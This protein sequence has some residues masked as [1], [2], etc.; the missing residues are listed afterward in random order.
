MY[1][2]LKKIIIGTANLENHYGFSK[3][4]LAIKEFKKILKLAKKKNINTLDIA[5]E[6]KNVFNIL[7]EQ[8]LTGWNIYSKISNIPNDK[9]LIDEYILSTIIQSL[10]NINFEKFKGIMIH[11]PWDLKKNN[12]HII[13]TTFKKI[14]KY[15]LSNEVGV[16]IYSNYLKK[17]YLDLIDLDFI[18]CPFNLVDQSLKKKGIIKFLNKKKIKIIIRSIFLQGIL[19]RKNSNGKKIFKNYPSFS[20]NFEKFIDKQK[21]LLKFNLDFI[22]SQNFFSNSVIGFDNFKQFNEINNLLKKNRERKAISVEEIK[23]FNKKII[24]PYEWTF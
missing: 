18:Q 5:P 16:S 8:D 10:K 22:F 1:N 13:N 3:T 19:L 17:D 12:C 7:N 14:K 2:D 15:K 23:S 6:Y 9:K 24:N 20:K 11:W 21:N 4:K